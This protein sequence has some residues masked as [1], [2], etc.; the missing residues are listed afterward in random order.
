[1]G[2][3][4]ILLC[5]VGLY[6]FAANQSAG[7]AQSK[8]ECA[9]PPSLSDAISSK[10]PGTHPASLADLGDDYTRKLYRKDF[11]TRCP[12]LVRVNFYGDGKPTWALLLIANERPKQKPELVVARQT[13]DAW[14]IRSLDK[15][16]GAVAVWREKPGKH[17]EIYGQKTIRATR[18]VIL[19]SDYGS[20][21]ILYSWTGKEVE[22]I[23]LSD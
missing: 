16:D 21:T 18:P 5:I 9:L 17:E 13:G 11:G 3:K 7:T 6:L 20:F 12:G 22:K 10:Y 15:A 1:V 19:I 4:S 8:S 2:L 23:W 14:D